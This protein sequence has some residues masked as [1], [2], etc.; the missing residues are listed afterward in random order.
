MNTIQIL[1]LIAISILLVWDIYLHIKLKRNKNRDH[2]YHELNSKLNFITASGSFALLAVSF[3]GWDVKDEILKKSEGPIKEMISEKRVEIDSLLANKNILKAGIYIV[4]DLEFKENKMFKF[5]DLLTI[6]HKH[7]PELTNAP[8]LLI[9]T[10][11]GENLRIEKVTNE[12]FILGK[13]ISKNYS[14][15]NETDN[16][17]YP[18]ILK[19]DIWIA[20]YKQK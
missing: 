14:L 5:R 8:K 13:P 1:V 9:N 4:T 20:D 16:P 3:L 19:F 11:T 12:Y 7:L 6:D 18:K 2:E 10:S 15:V 17:E